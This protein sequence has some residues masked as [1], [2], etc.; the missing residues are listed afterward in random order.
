MEV[1]EKQGHSGYSA[2]TVCSIFE[3]LVK[4]RP[5][6]PITDEED[7]WDEIRSI[8]HEHACYQHIR[9]GSLFKTVLKDGST[10]IYDIDRVQVCYEGYTTS[11]FN[12]FV[13]QIVS[14]QFPIK[15]PYVGETLKA[16]CEEVEGKKGYPAL[17]AEYEEAKKA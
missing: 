16:Q 3:R 15:F 17:K 2:I 4:G 7:Q 13:N 11:F 10:A 14:E 12:S 5:L 6:T 9:M 8:G 1:L